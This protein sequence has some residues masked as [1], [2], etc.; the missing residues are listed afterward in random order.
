MKVNERFKFWDAQTLTTNLIYGIRKEYDF[1][2]A[3]RKDVKD[4]YLPV[5]WHGIK[6]IN[7]FNSTLPN[8]LIIGYYDGEDISCVMLDKTKDMKE[9]ETI[10]YNAIQKYFDENGMNEAYVEAYM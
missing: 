2:F 4:G 10:I 1:T 3:L 5:G 9:Y 7:A 6:L 8:I